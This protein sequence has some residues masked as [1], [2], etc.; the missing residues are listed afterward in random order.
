MNPVNA[1]IGSLRYSVACPNCSSQAIVRSSAQIS[2]TTRECYCQCPNVPECGMTFKAVVEVTATI[3]PPPA[4][5][6]RQALPPR[7]DGTFFN[8][9]Q[10]D[11]DAD[12]LTLSL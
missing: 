5:G 8:Q 12:Q 6:I 11:S 2:P 9:L 7:V 4:E 3:N 1:R 10:P